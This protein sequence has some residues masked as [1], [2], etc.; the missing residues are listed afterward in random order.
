MYVIVHPR[1]PWFQAYIGGC[2]LAALSA[3]LP[4]EISSRGRIGFDG[5]RLSREL[6]AAEPSAALSKGNTVIDADYDMAL[7]A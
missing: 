3:T 2:N 6:R 4:G 5:G 1:L 7:A